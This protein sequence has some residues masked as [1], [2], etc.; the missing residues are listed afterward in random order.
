MPGGRRTPGPV[1]ARRNPPD[2][3]MLSFLPPFMRGAIAAALLFVNT[4]LL[5]RPAFR[6]RADQARRAGKSRARSGRP[7]AEC[8][9]DQLDR[10]QQRVDAADPAHATGTCRVGGSRLPRVVHGQLQPPVVGGHLR[11]PAPPEQAHP[12]AEVL[13]EAAAD[14]RAGDGPRLVGAG[15]P[16]HAAPLRRLPQGA[17]GEALRGPGDDAPRLRKIRAGA[18]ERDELRRKARASRTPSI[19]PSARRTGI[20]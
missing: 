17:S 4:L 14:L 9:R 20:C 6:R 2:R 19:A 5:V 12:D 18:D 8:D 7:V 10:R 16:V 3:P 13:P 15:F 1:A 11:A